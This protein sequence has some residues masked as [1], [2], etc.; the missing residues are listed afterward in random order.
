[1]KSCFFSLLGLFA[2]FLLSAAF[3][4]DIPLDTKHIEF[5]EIGLAMQIPA[6]WQPG[7]ISGKSVLGA[8]R[9]GKGLYPNLNITL[10]DHDGATLA[11]VMDSLLGKLPSPRIRYMEREKIDGRT[12]MISD[13]SWKSMLGEIRAIRLISDV[14]G[15]ILVITFVDK[16]A[17]LT[18]RSA[19]LYL[20]CLRSLR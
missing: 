10:E 9:K 1:M 16:T 17:Q 13:V 20:A 18:T 8:Y 2:L 4:S 12:V 14:K 15:K 11:Q 3:A 6:G 7:G 5:S 19:S